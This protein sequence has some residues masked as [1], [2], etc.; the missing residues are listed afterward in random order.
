MRKG[1]GILR[2]IEAGGIEIEAVVGTEKSW[3]RKQRLKRSDYVIFRKE[4][5]LQSASKR[6]MRRR[7]R[8]W[9]K[10]GHP[11]RKV[12]SSLNGELWQMTLQLELRPF[13]T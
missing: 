3:T 4:T 10:T 6:R 13:Q 5:N 7:P 2:G 11:R 8:S 1:T 9:L 12:N